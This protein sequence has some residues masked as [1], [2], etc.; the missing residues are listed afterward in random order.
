MKTFFELVAGE[1]LTLESL[2]YYLLTLENRARAAHNV[3]RSK[4]VT[5]ADANTQPDILLGALHQHINRLTHAVYRHNK[6]NETN[7]QRKTEIDGVLAWF[8]HNL[9]DESG[10]QVQ[11]SLAALGIEPLAFKRLI[12]EQLSY[13]DDDLKTVFGEAKQ[14]A[15]AFK[16]LVNIDLLFQPEPPAPLKPEDVALARKWVQR[17]TYV[18]FLGNSISLGEALRCASERATYMAGM[19]EYIG[20]ADPDLVK[21][22]R[23]QLITDGRV[24]LA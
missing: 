7:Q 22:A 2:Q 1:K 18:A 15:V 10:V 19:A 6:P 8:L 5:S 13:A 21:Y 24:Q 11:Q 4:L 23:N 16:V 12:I 20:R 14:A 9:K 3:D 17:Y